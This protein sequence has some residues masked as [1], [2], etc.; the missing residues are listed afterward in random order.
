ML[1]VVGFFIALMGV[2]ENI[3]LKS[4]QDCKNLITTK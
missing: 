4:L 1:L 3:F 2:Y